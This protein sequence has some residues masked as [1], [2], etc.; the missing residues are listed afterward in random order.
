MKHVDY[1]SP[2]FE[3]YNIRSKYGPDSSYRF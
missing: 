2:K 1:E 3:H